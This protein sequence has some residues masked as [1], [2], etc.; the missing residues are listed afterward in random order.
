M[1]KLISIIAAAACVAT[2]VSFAAC[3]NGET[4]DSS[5]SI[6][7]EES[8][9]SGSISSE[10]EST[11]SDSSATE[12]ESATPSD[13]VTAEEWVAAFAS[14]NF[15]NVTAERSLSYD[16]NYLT[17]NVGLS[18]A[19][20]DSDQYKKE[21]INKSATTTTK[22]DTEYSEG[23][24]VDNFDGYLSMDTDY[25]YE[26]ITDYNYTNVETL[27][28]AL[29]EDYTDWE[30]YSSNY[31]DFYEEYS[32]NKS[33]KDYV[34]CVPAAEGAYMPDSY[35]AEQRTEDGTT[36]DWGY[37]DNYTLDA[38]V[39]LSTNWYGYLDPLGSVNFDESGYSDASF[40]GREQYYTDS[41][42][43]EESGAYVYTYQEETNDPG[44]E[45]VMVFTYSGYVWSFEGSTARTYYVK[46][47]DGHV[48]SITMEYTYTYYLSWTTD[49]GTYYRNIETTSTA[50]F[51][52]YD[53]GTTTVEVPD[54]IKTALEALK[55]SE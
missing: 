48:S 14:E 37:L 30:A 27:K 43:D 34:L 39:A 40:L 45:Y 17:N 55:E 26:E 24:Y 49:V 31:A 28:N 35:I 7:E 41:E 52:F 12:E 19:Y 54:D 6:V 22:I 11:A 38:T 29:G 10:E 16:Y 23:K 50:E 1:K 9:A 21:T 36:G 46:I 4:S 32:T 25:S 8:T 42:Y 33:Y 20:Y 47:N 53:Y 15:A 5:G 44:E 2:C 3:G 13:I 18:D 51:E